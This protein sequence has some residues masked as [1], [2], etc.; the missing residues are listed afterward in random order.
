MENESPAATVV[1]VGGSNQASQESPSNSELEAAERLGVATE[2]AREATARAQALETENRELQERTQRQEAQIMNLVSE[3]SEIKAAIQAA[4]EAETEP[5]PELEVLAIVPEL[6]P[7]PEAEPEPER[8][9]GFFQTLADWV[10][11]I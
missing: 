7:E 1:V 6:E 10:N 8:P 3:V 2:A 5:E 9:R 4:A 11:S